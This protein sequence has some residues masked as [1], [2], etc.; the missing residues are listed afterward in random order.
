MNA[1][2]SADGHCGVGVGFGVL[3]V[4]VGVGIDGVGLLVSA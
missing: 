1:K 4:N 3:A 2:G